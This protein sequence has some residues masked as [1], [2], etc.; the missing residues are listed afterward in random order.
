[1]L[2]AALDGADEAARPAARGHS[3]PPGRGAGARQ[4]QLPE[5]SGRGFAARGKARRGDSGAPERSRTE[6]TRAGALRSRVSR[7]RSRGTSRLADGKRL[8]HSDDRRLRITA[9][10]VTP[11]R[12]RRAGTVSRRS[13]SPRLAALAVGEDSARFAAAG[14]DRSVSGWRRP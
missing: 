3:C 2:V 11:G 6:L 10:L 4:S 1:T 9:R 14:C 8:F 13:A 12:A 7:P 5:F